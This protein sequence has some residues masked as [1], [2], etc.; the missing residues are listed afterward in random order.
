MSAGYRLTPRAVQD[1]EDIAD[2][3]FKVWGAEQ[4]E[5]YL[6]RLVARFE[7]LAEKPEIGRP[8]DDVDTGYRCYPEGLH[9]IFYLVDAESGELAII[10]VPHSA[11]DI[12]GYFDQTP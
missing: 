3:T 11:M 8:R 1:L 4:M 6:R 2:Y 9:L 5:I 7:W 12:E 10:G